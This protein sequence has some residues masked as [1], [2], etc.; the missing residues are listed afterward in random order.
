MQFKRTRFIGRSVPVAVLAGIMAATP[1]IAPVSSAYAATSQELSSQLDAAKKKLDE[2]SKNLEIAQAKYD[3]T[4]SQLDETRSQIEDLKTQIAQKKEEVAGKQKSLAQNVS[5]SYKQ[6]NSNLV[7]ILVSSQNFSDLVSRM[8]YANKIND[9]YNSQIDDVNKLVKS[10]DEEQATLSAKEQDLTK[11]V[12]EQKKTKESLEASKNEAESYV[13]GLSSDLQAA[14][15]A[16][17]EAAAKKAAEEAAAAA[18]AAQQQAQ[19]STS[20]GN[21]TTTNRPS[22]NNSGTTTPSR[23]SGGSGTTGGGSSSGGSSAGGSLNG[24]TASVIISSATAQLGLP[25]VYGASQPGVAFDCSGLTSYAYR[26]AGI[27]IPHSSAGQ[28]NLVKGKGNLKTST[29]AL[30]PGDLVFYQSGGTIY[31]V[32]IYIGSGK[33][34]HANGYGQGVVITGVT[35]D[36]GFCGGGSPV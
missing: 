4:Q 8:F 19:Q 29:G 22:T 3:E 16:E 1:V 13:N 30:A 12:A 18:A 17:R 7:D 25:Y 23:P 14:L 26:C 31:H 5:S 2:L 20:N 9:K 10:L 34:V 33:V 27:S 11:L 21:S 28:Y 32:A 35:Y 6:G 36:D 24:S 15:A